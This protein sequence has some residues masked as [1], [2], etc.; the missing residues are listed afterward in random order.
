M[1][2]KDKLW[3]RIMS[4]PI[5]LDITFSE[6]EAFLISYGFTKESGKGDHVIFRHP[7][8]VSHLSI[9]CGRKHIKFNYINDVQKAINL[10]ENV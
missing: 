4:R 9:P 7:D 3:Q 10:L 2:K 8:L 1:T 5:K 6:V